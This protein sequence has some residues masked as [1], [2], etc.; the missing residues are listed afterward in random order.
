MISE[1]EN[2]I[3]HY[4]VKVINAYKSYG[5]NKIINGL[6]MNVASGSI[7]G[8]LGPSGCGK[9]TLLQCILGSIAL[10]SG[11][12]NLKVQSLSDV[13]YMPQDLCL[14]GK[15]NIKETLA[16]Y[17]ALHKMSEKNIVTRIKELKNIL[18]LPDLDTYIENLSGGQSRRVSLGITLFHDPEVVILDEPTVGLDS[19]LREQI[20]VEFRKMVEQHKTT[21]IITTHYIEEANQANCVGLMRN[22]VLVEEGL[23]RD[24]IAN[25]HSNSLES[26]FLKIC[27]KRQED[28]LIHNE[29][30][31]QNREVITTEAK[32]NN[33]KLMKSS[34]NMDLDRIKV[35][36]KKNVRTMFRD[37]A[38][39]F[40]MLILPIIQTFAICNAI[41]TNINDLAIAFQNDEIDFSDCRRNNIDGCVFNNKNNQ[42][43]S[44]DILNHLASLYT[45]N[46]MKDRNIDELILKKS[47]N[48]AF[49]HFPKN[50]SIQ[51]FKFFDD[52][53]N[54]NIESQVSVNLTKYNSLYT[55]R[56]L[57]DL[58]N[59]MNH[60]AE[61]ILNSCS[62]NPRALSIPVKLTV[63]SGVDV[64]S[65]TDC[66]ISIFIVMGTFYFPCIFSLTITLTDKMEGIISRSM[67][68]GVTI[69]EVVMSLFCIMNVLLILQMAIPLFMAYVL[70][71]RPIIITNGLVAY[72][73]LMILVGW[74]GFF[75]GIISACISSST[76]AAI[77][78]VNGFNFCQAILAGAAWPVEGQ[79]PLLQFVSELCPIRIAGNIMNNISLRGWTWEHPMVVA[80]ILKMLIYNVMLSLIVFILVK[81]KKD[82]WIKK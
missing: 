38:F 66:I 29:H 54:Y 9:S 27:Y 31:V 45:L 21:I 52:H 24:I 8:L 55:N 19:L 70:Y 41:G 74:T 69:A 42:T 13:G 11:S 48:I 23:P 60:V 50:Y 62:K 35:L 61:N 67:F 46:D 56:L 75:F 26:A 16:Y 81:F 39:L 53:E 4:D 3:V 18:S 14:D 59:T 33:N 80:S 22:G 49:I 17:G 32:H 36:I 71:G 79:F 73:V 30:C 40:T 20:W 76:L 5:V 15:L 63:V 64:K 78:A 77:Y 6:N 72:T 1:E 47:N 10:D 28:N 57:I 82:A 58:T 68:S 7:Y 37:Y 51:F 34:T 43:I 2:N 65:Y 12:I 44:C 25:N